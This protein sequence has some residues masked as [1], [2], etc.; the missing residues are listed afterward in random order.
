MSST[1]QHVGT[2]RFE[3]T[4]QGISSQDVNNRFVRVSGLATESEQLTWMQGT[5]GSVNT[6]PGRVK[7]AD[8]TL[9]RVYD[10]SDAFYRW[11]RYIERGQGIT[12]DVSVS[13]RKDVTV[14]LLRRDGSLA[15]EMQLRG[16]WPSRWQM[17]DLDATSS[18]PAIETIVL[19]VQEV[20]EP[21][22]D[23]TDE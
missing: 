11:R 18:N 16:A 12:A 13:Y 14:R 7:Y 3:V 9:E 2:F 22:L 5:D 6:A 19:T 10:G 1:D 20:Y 4:I 17:P 8:I 15:R 23:T 21:A